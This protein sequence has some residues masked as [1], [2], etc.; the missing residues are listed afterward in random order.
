M[1]ITFLCTFV[2]DHKKNGSQHAKKAET[3]IPSVLAAFL[4]RFILLLVPGSDAGA[5][6]SPPKPPSTD[7]LRD[8]MPADMPLI[9]RCLFR[10]AAATLLL[11]ETDKI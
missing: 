8:V 10:R 6:F 7:C 11:Q 9:C 2:T 5:V 3:I 1:K 4:S